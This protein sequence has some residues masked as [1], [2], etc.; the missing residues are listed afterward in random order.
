MRR[1]A[2]PPS[3]PHRY[4]RFA[5]SSSLTTVA[6]S[7]LPLLHSSPLLQLSGVP[8]LPLL[9]LSSLASP[10]SG[11][12]KRLRPRHAVEDCPVIQP[13]SREH[14]R[15]HRRQ[16]RRPRAP[17]SPFCLCRR[18]DGWPRPI[19]R[20]V[21]RP[22]GIVV[23]DRRHCPRR[24]FRCQTMMTTTAL[25]MRRRR[26]VLPGMPLTATVTRL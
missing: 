11:R 24:R 26:C 9:P 1:S 7:T 13:Q 19:P 3:N 14:C 18:P 12:E 4:A 10:S 2:T 25:M 16:C 6:G 17:S 22:D 20:H 5:E 23:V 8:L 21:L 15:H